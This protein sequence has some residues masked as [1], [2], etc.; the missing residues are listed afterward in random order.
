MDNK[1]SIVVAMRINS[2]ESWSVACQSHQQ[3]RLLEQAEQFED[4]HN[5]DNYSD[6]IKDVSVHAGDSYQIE[7]AV[8][9]IYTDWA[10]FRIV[11]GDADDS[12]Q[13][14]RLRKFLHPVTCCCDLCLR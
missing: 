3:G 5:N 9:S 1:A 13:C 12:M 4:D 6:Y 11:F 2:G 8:A 7:C 10:A 14:S